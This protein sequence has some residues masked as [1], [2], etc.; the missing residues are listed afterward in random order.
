MPGD[1]IINEVLF[2]PRPGGSDFIELQNKSDKYLNLGQVGISNGMDSLSFN[3]TYVIKPNDFMVITP[4]PI[5]IINEYPYSYTEKVIKQSLPSMPDDTG[6]IR[7][8]SRNGTFLEELV[9]DEKMHF[10][11]YHDVEGISLERISSDEPSSNHE[12][13][14]SASSISYGATPTLINSQNLEVQTGDKPLSIVPVAFDPG[15]ANRSFVTIQYSLDKPGYTG[16]LE[17]YHQGGKKIKTLYNA[18]FLPQNGFT[19]WEG[20]DESGNR[21]GTGPY[22]VFFQIFD[23]DGNVRTYKERV[24]VATRF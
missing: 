23:L 19:T 7:L 5:N 21:V 6:V 13:W 14:T 22:I 17:I 4:D 18:D 12:N 3:S 24:I 11:F 10:G 20:M 15:S 9:Y 16:T 8:Y 1:L 2:N